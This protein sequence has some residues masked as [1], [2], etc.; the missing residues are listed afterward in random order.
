MKQAAAAVGYPFTTWNNQGQLTQYQQGFQNAITKKAS[1]IDL[2]AGPDPNS[3]K[4]QIDEAQKAG[5]KVVASHLTLSSRRCRTWTTTCRRTTR[6]PAGRL[7]TGSSRMTTGLTCCSSA[8]TRSC[9]PRL[10]TPAT[11]PRWRSMARTSRPR[12][13]TSRSPS[14]AP[15]SSRRCSRP[16][17]PT[18]N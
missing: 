8:P 5:I 2:L 15:R 14:G 13:S 16:S 7:P 11:M 12:T 1:L 3:L 17:W 6:R 9:R 18:P 4:P 10:R